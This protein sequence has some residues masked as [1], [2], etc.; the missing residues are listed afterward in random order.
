MIRE[1]SVDAGDRRHHRPGAA[2]VAASDARGPC[3]ARRPGLPGL[4]RRRRLLRGVRRSGPRDGPRRRQP[5]RGIRG[6]DRGGAPSGGAS[7]A[8]HVFYVE[9]DKLE[10]V[11][12]PAPGHDRQYV[13]RPRLRHHRTRTGATWYTFP[14]AAGRDRAGREHA[15]RRHARAS[16]ATWSPGPRSCRRP[17]GG[18][19]GE[20]VL[21]HRP[22]RVGQSNWFLLGRAWENGLR[23]GL[24]DTAPGV[25]PSPQTSST[26]ATAL[27]G[28][29]IL[30]AFYEGAG[31]ALR[32]ARSGRRARVAPE[33]AHVRP[34][35]PRGPGPDAA[36]HR[37]RRPSRRVRRGR[38]PRR[39]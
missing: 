29:R 34:G 2:R 21:R 28:L 25:H 7:G 6:P 33:P 15:H 8:R 14:R 30:G 16:P 18:A 19:G 5:G 27:P 4:R 24:I 10:F 20:P 1:R 13:A 9:S 26:P 39:G 12:D 22:A 38:R 35:G 11:R 36:A 3:R 37:G 23:V 17:R 32:L 31:I